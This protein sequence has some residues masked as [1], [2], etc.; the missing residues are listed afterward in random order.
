MASKAEL[1]AALLSGLTT[2]LNENGYNSVIVANHDDLYGQYKG[3]AGYGRSKSSMSH[4][5]ITRYDEEGKVTFYVLADVRFRPKNADKGPTLRV[6]E[7]PTGISSGVT[8]VLEH[9]LEID[10]PKCFQSMLSA[11][12][13]YERKLEEK[14]DALKAASRKGPHDGFAGP[15]E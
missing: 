6:N 15:N 11:V 8:H 7:D 1:L 9:L 12:R 4:V 5:E 2:I 14:A 3:F 10:N 13:L